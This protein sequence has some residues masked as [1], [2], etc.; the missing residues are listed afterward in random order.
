MR[1]ERLPGLP[2][3]IRFPREKRARPSRELLWEIKP[4]VREVLNIAEAFGMESPLGDTREEADRAMAEHI[5][6]HVVP[7]PGPLRRQALDDLLAP[8]IATAVEAC[9]EAMTARKRSDEAAM[10]L[11]KAEVEGGTWMAPLIEDVNVKATMA[12]T[13][14]VE[15][16][17]VAEEA[18]GAARAIG[19]AMRG[20]NWTR[21]D[22]RAE[23]DALFSIKPLEQSH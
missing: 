2:N 7:E 18:E 16:Y 6:N 8:L 14:M 13:R 3:V 10:L 20:E 22:I 21:R 5:L 11:A 17:L 9:R 15:A 23:T 19:L 12:A 1:I 4:D